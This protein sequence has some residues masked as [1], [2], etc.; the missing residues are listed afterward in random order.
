MAKENPP[1]PIGN[2]SSNGGFS[3]AMLVCWRVMARPYSPWKDAALNPLVS[4]SIFFSKKGG[5]GYLGAGGVLGGFIG[6]SLI[7][8]VF[9]GRI[10]FFCGGSSKVPHGYGNLNFFFLPTTV[11]GKVSGG[12]NLIS[13]PWKSWPFQW[14]SPTS[15][16]KVMLWWSLEALGQET[17]RYSWFLHAIMV[18]K[19]RF[20]LAWHFETRPFFSHWIVEIIPPT[21]ILWFVCV[22]TVC[23]LL[24][25]FKN[26]LKGPKLMPQNHPF[27]PHWP[28]KRAAFRPRNWQS[29]KRRQGLCLEQ[30]KFML[31]VSGTHAIWTWRKAARLHKCGILVLFLRT[32]P[33]SKKHHFETSDS[34]SDRWN[35][36][37]HWF[38]ANKKRIM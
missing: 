28:L 5:E 21:L 9:L 31:L 23:F 29:R 19:A 18:A 14:A 35:R 24:F 11:F 12:S 15:G 2:T 26:G 33:V 30:L 22:F 20:L 25:F 27:L 1:F 16:E 8:R 38:P 7:L 32:S 37:K 6:R 17:H 10:F 3:I 34:F 4:Q 13:D 36:T